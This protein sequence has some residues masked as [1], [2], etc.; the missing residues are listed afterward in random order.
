MRE[1]ELLKQQLSPPCL[2]CI[3]WQS[4]NKVTDTLNCFQIFFSGQLAALPT[5]GTI[6]WTREF[7]FV[8]IPVSRFVLKVLPGLVYSAL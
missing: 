7:K 6:I 5:S 3:P 2:W 1:A 4:D 8:S